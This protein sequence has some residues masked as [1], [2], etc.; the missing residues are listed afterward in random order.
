MLFF[1]ELLYFGLV[2]LLI[3]FVRF[4]IFVSYTFISKPFR[5]LIYTIS[6]HQSQN[7]YWRRISL[8]LL[9]NIHSINHTTLYI[10][11]LSSYCIHITYII[12]IPILIIGNYHHQKYTK[13]ILYSYSHKHNTDHI[14]YY[15]HL[16]Q[17]NFIQ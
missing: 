17:T 4:N 14:T 7:I 1:V 11:I 10:H 15:I 12:Q 2:C 9:F 13:C 8:L 6:F 3:F 5:I 16:T